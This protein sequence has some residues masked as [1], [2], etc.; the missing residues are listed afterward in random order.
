MLGDPAHRPNP[1]LG[2]IRTAP[3]YAVRLFP[4][5]IGSTRG[6]RT[7]TQARVRASDGTPVEGL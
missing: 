4:G 2:P 6:L 3:F 1:C 7:D 5:N